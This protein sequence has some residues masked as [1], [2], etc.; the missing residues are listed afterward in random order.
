MARTPGANTRHAYLPETPASG[1]V[2]PTNDAGSAPPTQGAR[3][4][5]T[6]LHS[7]GFK[8]GLASDSPVQTGPSRMVPGHSTAGARDEP[9]VGHWPHAAGSRLLAC[10]L[11]AMMGGPA[12]HGGSSRCPGHR[13]R[14]G[15]CAARAHLPRPRHWSDIAS[16]DTMPAAHSDLLLNC[17]RPKALR[18]VRARAPAARSGLNAHLCG[19]GLQICGPCLLSW[20]SCRVYCCA[21]IGV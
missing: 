6:P 14:Q 16:R 18:Y 15:A 1:T 5:I 21:C 20:L 3:R 4:R 17:C 13:G 12:R 9:A 7:P 2:T 19:A 8:L 10:P 11:S